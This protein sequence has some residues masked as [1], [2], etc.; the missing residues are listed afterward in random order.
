MRNAFLSNLK[1]DIEEYEVTENRVNTEFM[2]PDCL[3]LS[4]NNLDEKFGAISP[5]QKRQYFVELVNYV[6]KKNCFKWSEV[7]RAFL[8]V[9]LPRKDTFRRQLEH[10]RHKL[11]KSDSRSLSRLSRQRSSI[12]SSMMNSPERQ[13]EQQKIKKTTGSF[14]KPIKIHTGSV[15]NSFTGENSHANVSITLNSLERP[16]AVR[17]KSSHMLSTCNKKKLLSSAKKRNSKHRDNQNNVVQQVQFETRNASSLTSYKKQP[18]TNFKT[19][20]KN[21]RMTNANRFS[22]NPNPEQNFQE[23]EAVQDELLT[24]STNDFQ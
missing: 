7:L 5:D 9:D 24:Q 17:P 15:T 16:M 14:K 21:Q 23:L 2:I 8:G 4:K 22:F 10:I 18:F 12:A 13:L 20:P 11:R 3:G 1:H 19:Q 6:C